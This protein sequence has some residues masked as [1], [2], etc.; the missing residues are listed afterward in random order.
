MKNNKW[1][2]LVYVHAALLLWAL[3]FIICLFVP[4][5]GKAAS[6]LSAVNF[7]FLFFNIPFGVLSFILKAKDLFD[8]EYEDAIAVLSVLNIIIGIIAWLF[9]VLLWLSPKIG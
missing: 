1:N 3:S 6:I 5:G 8:I 7:L 4:G 2:I 9:V